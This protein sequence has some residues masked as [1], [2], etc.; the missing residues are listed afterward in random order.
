MKWMQTDSKFAAPNF[1]KSTNYR[2]PEDY[3]KIGKYSLKSLGIDAMKVL[4]LKPIKKSRTHALWYTIRLK[5]T[6]SYLE[7]SNK[8]LFLNKKRWLVKDSSFLYPFNIPLSADA[9]NNGYNNQLHS[10]VS[11]G[12]SNWRCDELIGNFGRI[13][14]A[15]RKES[16]K[17]WKWRK[18]AQ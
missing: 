7:K 10:D 17:S 5:F 16:S 3:P 2:K 9:G 15:W 12:P 4:I 18:M 11:I 6:V 8:S 13:V 1:V 14:A